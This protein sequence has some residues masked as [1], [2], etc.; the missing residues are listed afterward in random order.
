VVGHRRER[1]IRGVR[2]VSLLPSATDMIADLGLLDSLVGVSDDCNWPPEVR[3]KPL[4][5]RTRVDLEGL[6]AAQIDEIVNSSESDSHSLYAVDATLMDELHPDLVITQDLC[7]VCAV[8]SGDL[9][10]ACPIGTEVF[11][12]NARTLDEVFASV[13]DLAE[14]L[15]V[16]DRGQ[17]LMESMRARIEAVR[18]AVAGRARPRVFVAEWMDPPYG[19]GHWIPE[20]VV[21]AGGENLLSSPGRPS[22]ATSW[23]EVLGSDPELIVLAACGFDLEQS[24]SRCRSLGLPVPTV[25]VD[26]DA[27]FSRPAPR[28]ADGVRQLGH[29]LHPEAVEDPGLPSARLPLGVAAGPRATR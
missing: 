1:Y 19:S 6:S 16:P 22:F 7:Q 14:R 4:V 29:L 2:I 18:E 3:E 26:G 10:T 11:S 27:Y 24:L 28:L 12:I 17:A 5:A 25:V 9:Q 8:S 23:E 13:L 20:M 15:G 21:A